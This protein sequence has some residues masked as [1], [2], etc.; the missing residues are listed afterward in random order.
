M[1]TGFPILFQQE[2]LAE[3]PVLI[4]RISLVCDWLYMPVQRTGVCFPRKPLACLCAHQ[5]ACT[6]YLWAAQGSLSLCF[7]CL[8][9]TG[10]HGLQGVKLAQDR[11]APEHRQRR[12]LLGHSGSCHLYVLGVLQGCPACHLGGSVQRMCHLLAEF[13]LGRE[14]SVHTGQGHWWWWCLDETFGN[15]WPEAL[16]S[17]STLLWQQDAWT[18]SMTRPVACAEHTISSARQEG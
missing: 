1:H 5:C 2:G 6:G 13:E 10:L 14:D 11:R 3:L 12:N 8:S 7:W 15:L 9:L 18:P 16:Q 17:H 4:P